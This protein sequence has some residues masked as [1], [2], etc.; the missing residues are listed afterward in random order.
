MTGASEWRATIESPYHISAGG[1]VFRLLG[2]TVEVVVLMRRESHGA[3]YHLPKG[4]LRRDETLENCACREV[5]EES[6][7]S[8]K[9]VS[10]LG[11]IHDKFTNPNNQI[12]IDKIS[13]YFAMECVAET[14][15]HDAEHDKVLW[16]EIS[17]A[18]E[19]LFKTE[20]VKQEFLILDRLSKFISK[21]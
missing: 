10:Y 2:D 20:K 12:L 9:I 4:T 19:L 13:H 16:M 7:K 8:C 18:R 1:A 11:A 17:K 6:G 3:S 5:L 15:A 14:G 21:N